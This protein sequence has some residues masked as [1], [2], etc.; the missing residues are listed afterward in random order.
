MDRVAEQSYVNKRGC[1]VFCGHKD[2]S[3]Y[4][5]LH[6]GS[7]LI[8]VHR[9]IFGPTKKLVCHTCDNPAC[10]N[11]AHLFEGTQLDNMRDRKRK[12]RYSFRVS[13][14]LKQVA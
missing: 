3:G 1:F 5:R 8:R 6:N 11:K 14:P 9:F 12:G 10:W 7:K 4:G 2:E 13:E